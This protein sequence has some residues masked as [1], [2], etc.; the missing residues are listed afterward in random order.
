MGQMENS[1][2]SGPWFV[3]QLVWGI[4]FLLAVKYNRN[5]ETISWKKL[6]EMHS[7]QKAT[8]KYALEDYS[9]VRQMLYGVLLEG[10]SR[11]KV[12]IQAVV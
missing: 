3:R 10:A 1:F 11:E 9:D 6:E 12:L 5:M 7:Y 8:F 4:A 2:S